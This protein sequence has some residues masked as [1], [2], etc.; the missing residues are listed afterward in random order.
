MIDWDEYPLNLLSRSQV[1]K[2][3]E[4]SSY[5]V[6]DVNARDLLSFKRFDIY[7]KLLYIDHKVKGLD[8]GYALEVYKRH[9][10][11]ITGYTFKEFGQPDKDS[12]EKYVKCFDNLID[13]FKKGEYD[14]SLSLIPV[15]ADNVPIDGSHRVSCAVYFNQTIRVVKFVNYR[16]PAFSS[17]WFK[18]HY[19]LDTI[20]NSISLEFCNWHSDIYMA[21]LWPNACR[22]KEQREVAIALLEQ[23]FSV[24][25]ICRHD[26]GQNGLRNLLI[27]VY[28]F[29]SWT[30]NASNHFSGIYNKLNEI[31]TAD[32]SVVDFILFQAVGLDEVL[33][34][35]AQ[36][37][38]IFRMDKGAIHITDNTEET[39][40]IANLIYNP[41]SVHHLKYACPDKF[42][43]SYNMCME[44]KSL[45]LTN[46]YDLSR[47]I[48]DS[49]S[50]MAV[51]GIREAGD[52]DYLT[53]D[54]D[55]KKRALHSIELCSMECHDKLKIYHGI[56]V[57]DM[58]LNPQNYFVFNGL[59]FLSL[60]R[61]KIFKRNKG[62]EKDLL[63]I[64]LIESFQSTNDKY[65][66][67]ILLLKNYYRRRKAYLINC[68]KKMIR[69][70]LLKLCLLDFAKKMIG[71]KSI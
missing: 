54:S 15:D 1:E 61:I 27:Q 46:G 7:A 44:F 33:S 62:E 50:V 2:A 31:S 49:S 55:N 66:Y 9:L 5:I 4:V 25:S 28:G 45:L 53:V 8:M 58:V 71:R 39:Y 56:P 14:P 52:L 21:C 37:R 32:N 13:I 59:K 6:E 67:K 51:Y 40:Q 47:Y 63:D 42:L 43:C 22:M 16:R 68:I 11:V 64:R 69:V 30:G 41:N 3:L 19:L 65:V 24:V 38:D 17:Q 48:I 36:I 70:I 35:K 23:K 29:M 57:N 34:V 20:Q 18:E 12:F 60:E 10:D 26:L